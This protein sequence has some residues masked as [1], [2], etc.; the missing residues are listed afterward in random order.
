MRKSITLSMIM[1]MV[2]AI[3]NRD[4]EVDITYV[5]KAMDRTESIIRIKNTK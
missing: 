5:E 3:S 2:T 4:T 1:I